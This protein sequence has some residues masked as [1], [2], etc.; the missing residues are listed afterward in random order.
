MPLESDRGYQIFTGG[1]QEKDIAAC[2]NY[3]GIDPKKIHRVDT[4]WNGGG[5]DVGLDVVI[6]IPAYYSIGRFIDRWVP[7]PENPDNESS[8][9]QKED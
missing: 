6:R 1:D 8:V 3:L 7:K 5:H 9:P 4:V 2:A